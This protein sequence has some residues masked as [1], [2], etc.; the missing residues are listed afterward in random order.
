MKETGQLVQFCQGLGA[1]RSQAEVMAAQ[2]LKRADQLAVERGVTRDAALARLLEIVAT[3]R[4][5]KVPEE[6]QPPQA[7]AK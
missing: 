4:A 2:L 1:S 3:G 6:F 5:G 7:D